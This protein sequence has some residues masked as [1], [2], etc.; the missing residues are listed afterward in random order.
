MKPFS[1][2]FRRLCDLWQEIDHL[3]SLEELLSWDQE[4][5]M[6]SGGHVHRAHLLGTV[7]SLRHRAL[8]SQPLWESIEQCGAVG[9]PSPLERATLSRA[10]RITERA[11]TMPTSLARSIAEASSHGIRAWQ[12][13]RH[14]E[15]FGVFRTSLQ[16]LVRLKREE[17]AACAPGEN[18]YEVLFQEYEP[19]FRLERLDRI[20]GQLEPRLQALV[21]RASEVSQAQPAPAHRDF[22]ETAQR[23]LGLRW[24]RQVG[25][26]FERS[27]LDR[28]A[29]PF[30]VGISP[31]DVRITWRSSPHD[32][33]PALF[34]ILHEMGHALYEQGIPTE[35]FATPVG[36]AAS[37]GIHESQSRLWE[38]HVGRSPAFW[39]G[40][41]PAL[42]AAFPEHAPATLE[43][44]MPQL[45]GTCPSLIRVDA[46]ETTYDLHIVIRYRL[47]RAL[48]EGE[49]EVAELPEAWNEL[50]EA[51]LG[52]TPKTP[53]EGV[54]QDI[55]WASGLFGY[56]PTYTLGSLASAQLFA[57]AGRELH[58]LEGSLERMDFAPLLEWL[59]HAVH[60]H[61][62]SMTPDE[63]LAAATGHPLE[64]DDYLTHVESLVLGL[65]PASDLA[66]GPL[67]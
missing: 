59:R 63:L 5:Q 55:H 66:E 10:R 54:L 29:H 67:E 38:N 33:R 16:E 62:A 8:L 51:L 46:D 25:L 36:H 20:F 1:E 58:D 14:R 30:C 21:G 37:L 44:L 9:D 28:S 61:G 53:S 31:D 26:D 60:R 2:P 56:F 6:P 65:D 4:T 64:A 3:G 45:R 23:E 40:A 57:A 18:P 7:A 50:Y 39:R 47:E 41:L 24:C 17:A 22:P 11:R 13:A 19:G 15:D 35:W 43:E 12:E 32:W 52:V 48:I 34:G 42:R 49:L 27:R